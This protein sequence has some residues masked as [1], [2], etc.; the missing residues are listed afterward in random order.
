MHKNSDE[1]N[2]IRHSI[3]G[4]EILSTVTNQTTKI[5]KFEM[6]TKLAIAAVTLLQ[7]AHAEEERVRVPYYEKA[8]GPEE[9]GWF[10]G[11]TYMG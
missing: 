7:L 1:E 2:L 5:F 3:K 10:K 4:P 6:L 11:S 9:I 8:Q